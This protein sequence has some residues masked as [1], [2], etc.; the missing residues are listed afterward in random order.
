MPSHI[1]LFDTVL[2]R[3]TPW[4]ARHGFTSAVDVFHAHVK[5]DRESGTRVLMYTRRW[6]HNQTCDAD[7]GDGDDGDNGDDFARYGQNDERYGWNGGHGW[8]GLGLGIH[9]YNTNTDA[10]TAC[11]PSKKTCPRPK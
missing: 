11:A 9:K 6:E 1:V 2:P 10:D 7:D 8:L 4:L 5:V 3:V